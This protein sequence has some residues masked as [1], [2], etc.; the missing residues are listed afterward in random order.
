MFLSSAGGF[1]SR[2]LAAADRWDKELFIRINDTWS[3]PFFD[4]IF[5]WW[6]YQHTWT[7]LYVLLLVYI[8]YRFG[9][10]AWPWILLAVAAPALGD[11]ISSWGIKEWTGRIRPCNSTDLKGIMHLRVGYCP[12]S[13]SFTS[14][15]AVNHFAMGMFFYLTLKPYIKRWAWLFLFWAATICYGQVYVGVHYPGDVLGGA[16]VGSLIGWGLAYIFNR[17]I[18][19]R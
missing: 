18:G 2:T 7:P 9:W 13:G 12:Q 1:F 6:R 16:I 10:K 15:H 17:K 5:P 8:L 14:S 11:L 3:N 4:W 19:F